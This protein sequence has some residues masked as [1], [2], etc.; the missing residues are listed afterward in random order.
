MD[1]LLCNCGSIFRCKVGDTI[2]SGIYRWYMS[3]YCNRCGNAIEMDGIGVEDIPADVQQEMIKEYGE[4]EVLAKNQFSKVNY[5]M[6]K[7]FECY[8]SDPIGESTQ[9]VYKGTRNQAVFIKNCLIERGISELNLEIR[10][11]AC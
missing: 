1:N 9:I 6:K 10:R 4:W 5:L 8:A 2:Q 3:S 7:L 11:S